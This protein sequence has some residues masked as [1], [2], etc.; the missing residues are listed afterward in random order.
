MM[1]RV[2]KNKRGQ[3][4]RFDPVKEQI[5]LV[6]AQHLVKKRVHGGEERSTAAAKWRNVQWCRHTEK[7]RTDKSEASRE[8]DFAAAKWRKE[9]T[10]AAYE[11]GACRCRCNE[12]HERECVR[13]CM[14]ALTHTQACAS[15][16]RACGCREKNVRR[17]NFCVH[18][19]MRESVCTCP[20]CRVRVRACMRARVCMRAFTRRMCAC[21][22]REENVRLSLI[23]I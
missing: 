15:R 21:V 13:V 6:H 17:D 23:H 9:R 19:C 2:E 22:C 8:G 1:S 10:T 20:V 12:V 3:T 18:T 14:L 16:M 11:A 5:Y 4:S 7:E